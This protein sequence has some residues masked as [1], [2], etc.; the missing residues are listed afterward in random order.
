[1]MAQYDHIVTMPL[2]I[3][4]GPYSI[5]HVGVARLGE[6]IAQCVGAKIWPFIEDSSYRLC[7]L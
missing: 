6:A 2:C 1:M 3:L 7:S 5:F 4:L